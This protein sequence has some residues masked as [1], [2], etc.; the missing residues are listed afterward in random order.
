MAGEQTYEASGSYL[1]SWV[2]A[3]KEMKLFDRARGSLDEITAR[4]V[5]A[6]QQRSWW[7]PEIFETFLLSLKLA[8]GE[9][10]IKDASR[11]STYQTMGAIARPL[12]SVTLAVFGGSPA[13]LASRF[14]S[15]TSVG[16]RGLT[17]EWKADGKN[18]GTLLMFWPQPVPPELAGIW[19]GVIEFGFSVTT[20]GRIA[21]VV[22]QPTQHSFRLEW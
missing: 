4:A 12:I 8:G 9:G 11:I 18:A 5:D 16:L 6:P 15:F 20:P 3:A 7:S 2:K 21:S 17:F 14:G 1:G 22:V 10:A 13:T 19:Y